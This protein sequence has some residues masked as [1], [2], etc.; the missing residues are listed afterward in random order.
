MLLLVCL[1]CLVSLNRRE[2]RECANPDRGVEGEGLRV[3]AVG[4][5]GIRTG[6]GIRSKFWALT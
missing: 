1:N 3:R 4:L 5:G 2:T 6:F